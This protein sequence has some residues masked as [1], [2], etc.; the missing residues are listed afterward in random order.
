MDEGKIEVWVRIVGDGE[1]YYSTLT[2]GAPD[3]FVVDLIGVVNMAP[4]TNIAVE[5][6]LVERIRVAQYKPYPE[7]V[8]RVVVDLR[9]PSRA[10]VQPTY[11]G[12]VLAFGDSPVA[13]AAPAE[14]QVAETPVVE[15][16]AVEAR[17]EM[18]DGLDELV[19]EP[20]VEVAEAE[21]PEVSTDWQAPT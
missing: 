15:P 7:P 19:E 2:L 8:S 6:D 20:I 9:E 3:R 18:I 1:F 10:Q 4:N 5:S 21:T 17:E 16:A 12:L 14:F 11:D 13:D